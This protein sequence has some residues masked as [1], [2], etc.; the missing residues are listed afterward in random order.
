MLSKKHK[1][2]KMFG[3][4]MSSKG[5]WTSVTE[6]SLVRSYAAWACFRHFRFT[7]FAEPDDSSEG[8]LT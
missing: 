1:L 8:D 6:E 7:V 4:I 5:S 2:P 3:R